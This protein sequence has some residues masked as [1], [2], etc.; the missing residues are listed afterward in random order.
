M[1]ISQQISNGFLVCPK[2]KQPLTQSDNKLYTTSRTTEYYFHN[3]API[4]INPD[5]FGGVNTPMAE[6]Y[7]QC[8]LSLKEKFLNH[9]K[10]WLSKDFRSSYSQNIFS[11]LLNDFSSEHLLLSIGGGPIRIH[12]NLTNL[13]INNFPN[14]D[15]VADAHE[16]P[17]QDKVVDFIHCEAV[18]EHL[19]NP[20]LAVQEMHRVLKSGAKAYI[21]TPFLQPYHGYPYHFQNFT[22]QGHEQ[23]FKNVGFKTLYKGT[24]V[25]PAYMLSQMNLLFVKKFLPRYLSILLWPLL[26]VFFR[27]FLKPLDLIINN[28]DRA[29]EAASTTFVVVEK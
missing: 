3:G 2:T 9:F 8:H 15:V 27:L 13:N 17:Y 21:V 20:Q 18:L 5:Q 10:N 14:V 16:L 12:P 6:E 26:A 22:L 7:L 11:Q 25:G 24:C 1:D 4:F 23:L 28:K 29:H 19:P